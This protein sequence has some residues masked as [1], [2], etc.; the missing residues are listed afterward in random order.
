MIA[1]RILIYTGDKIRI[2]DTFERSFVTKSV[3]TKRMK[4]TEIVPFRKQLD[5]VL[6]ITRPEIGKVIG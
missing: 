1:I 3:K 4:I 2:S 5:K 6:K